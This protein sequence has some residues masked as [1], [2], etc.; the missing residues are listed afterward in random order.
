MNIGNTDFILV[1]MLVLG[2]VSVDLARAT[3]PQAG[4]GRPWRALERRAQRR[5]NAGWKRIRMV[6]SSRRPA[7]MAPERVTTSPGAVR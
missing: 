3:P 1:G 7:I 6:N 4:V 2:G 5:Q